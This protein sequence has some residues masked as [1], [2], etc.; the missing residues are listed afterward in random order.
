MERERFEGGS[1]MERPNILMVITH[2]TGR[3]LGCYGAGV[4]TPALDRMADEGVLFTSAFAYAPQCSPSRASLLSGLAPHSNGMIGLAHLGFRLRPDVALLPAL[5]GAAGY[6]TLLFGLQHETS[7]DPSALGYQHVMRAEPGRGRG[8]PNSLDAVVPLVTAFLSQSPAEPFFAMVGFSETHRPYAHTT[9]DLREIIPPPFLPEDAIVRQDIADLNAQVERVD[10]ALDRILAALREQGLSSRTIVIYTTDHGVAF[11]GAKATLLDPGLGIA[12]LM[13]GPGIPVGRRMEALIANVDM[14]P[15]LCDLAGTPHPAVHG[16]SLVPLFR[17]AKDRV[18]CAIYPEMTFHGSYDPVRAVRTDRFKYIRSYQERPWLFPANIDASPTKNFFAMRG[19][20]DRSRP[21]E[22][23]F[24]LQEDPLERY[25]IAESA[26]RE[27]TLVEMRMRL[28]E[29][30]RATGDPLLHGPV[31]VP[32]GAR[33]GS[34]SRRKPI[35]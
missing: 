28:D 2:D 33:V 21:R 8:G 26:S 22:L 6:Q 32:E 11:P 31:P 13:K 14:L 9:A 10:Q 25:N 4:A 20:F 5:L 23:L 27:Q 16:S 3:H 15:T 17:E 19:D 18:H 12:W 24:D 34:G 30:M 7:G 1:R 29:W 35:T